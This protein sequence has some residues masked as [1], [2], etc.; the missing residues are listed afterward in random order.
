MKDIKMYL[1]FIWENLFGVVALLWMLYA[2]VKHQPY[3]NF[4]V[5]FGLASIYWELK[6]D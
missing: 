1:G 5:V 6:H 2:L 3:F 4:L